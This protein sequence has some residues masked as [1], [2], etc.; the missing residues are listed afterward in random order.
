MIKFLHI[1]GVIMFLGNI[2]IS[3][4]W[5]LF[6]E[7]S[8]EASVVKQSLKMIT[9]TDLLFSLPGVIL[10]G[11]TGHILSPQFG[12]IAGHS[13]IYHSYAML[14][15]SVLIWLA[16]LIPIQIKQRRLLATDAAAMESPQFKKL[17]LWWTL[18]SA[19]VAI[20]P[21]IALYY[22]TIKPA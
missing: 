1:I 9:L 3:A 2:T 11:V 5:R 19:I 20:L 16:A 13:W 10:I 12:G 14:T 21:L 22:M 15:V 7:K 18:L 8:G 4:V 6:A 17:T